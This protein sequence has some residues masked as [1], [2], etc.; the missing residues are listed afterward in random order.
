MTTSPLQAT[1]TRLPTQHRPRPLLLTL[2]LVTGLLLGGC[3]AQQAYREGVRLTEAGDREAALRQFEEAIRLDKGSAVY[4]VAAM[5]AREGLAGEH[6][7]QFEQL[8][9]QGDLDGASNVFLLYLRNTAD[10]DKLLARLRAAGQVH[11][12]SQWLEQAQAFADKGDQESAIGLL[13]RILAENPRHEQAS[14]LLTQWSTPEATKIP[15]RQ[16]ALNKAFKTPITIEF[17]DAPL[18]A[19]FEV[20]SRTS[21]LNFVFDRDVRTD[22]KTSLFLRNS[23][24]ES[25]IRLALLTNQ[26]EQRV[27]D[28]NSILIYPNSA[29]KQKDY[30]SLS[31][32]VFYLA[33]AEAK[34]VAA[35]LKTILKS[36]DIVVDDKLNMIILRDS[37]EA[38]RLAEK[39]VAVHDVSEPEVML[40]VEILEVNRSR[41]LDLGVRWPDQL[42]LNPIAADGTN[43]TLADLWSASRDRSGRTIGATVGSTTLRAQKTD[44]DTDLLANPRIRVRNRDKARVLI[45][46]RVPNITSTST[47]TGFVAESITYVDVGLKLDVEPIIYIDGEVAIKIALEVSNIVEQLTTKSGTQAY[48]IGTRSAQTVLRLRD[49]ENQVL[50]GLISNEDR[51]AANKV[52][53]LGELPVAGRL[54]GARSDNTNRTEIV[55]SITPRILRNVARPAAHFMEF[56]SGTDGNLGAQLAAPVSQPA[57]ASNAASIS[58]PS[59]TSI[60]KAD[61]ASPA[62]PPPGTEPST[63]PTEP[64]TPNAD[65]PATDSPPP[66]AGAVEVRWQA[67]ALVSRSQN[68][69]VQLALQA[70]SPVMSVPMS[71]GFDASAL[72]VVSVEEGNLLKQ[73]GSSSSF[74]HRVDPSGQ[75]L[76]TTTRA[77]AGNS[78]SGAAS[79]QSGTVASIT[80]RVTSPTVTETQLRVLAVAPVGQGGKALNT[81]LPAAQTLSINP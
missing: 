2:I 12:H 26:L 62:A 28:G 72:Q 46:D 35:S 40:E 57:T 39:L 43:L 7:L 31:V 48:R 68:F 38:V 56:E 59:A 66:A 55:L 32:K 18:R 3:A 13:R 23:T 69:T 24:V 6:R 21:G 53:G 25:A 70:D 47:S 52:P 54:F 65:A 27:L 16:A 8:L 78:A 49:G 15:G 29:A 34:N 14:R 41:L 58:A 51:S 73:G 33:N 50:A 74:V 36:R 5:H 22:Q 19:V 10:A 67:P 64:G 77:S 42:S 11:N 45:G 81:P 79:G 61:P 37:P 4:R 17:K 1:P 30:Q 20:I 44:S 9:S 75:I 80:F 71:L 76:L 60:P 63:P